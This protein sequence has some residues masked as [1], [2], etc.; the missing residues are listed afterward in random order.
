VDLTGLPEVRLEINVQAA[1]WQRLASI[2]IYQG[3][4]V[5]QVIDLD[6]NDTTP[7]RFSQQ[8][9]V[10]TPTEDTFYVVRVDLESPGDP[11]LTSIQLPSVT[12]PLFVL[13]P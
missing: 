13:A 12:N 9:L 2:T 5:L 11:V 4:Q 10:P 6:E 3:T 8:V 1:P 7:L